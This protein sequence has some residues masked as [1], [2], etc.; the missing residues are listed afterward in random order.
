M[1]KVL[2]EIS[3]RTTNSFGV[4]NIKLDLSISSNLTFE[5]YKTNYDI[6]ST[7]LFI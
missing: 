3:S 6:K 5:P 4:N 2:N 7:K 1:E